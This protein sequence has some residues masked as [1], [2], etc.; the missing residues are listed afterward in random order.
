MVDMMWNLNIFQ[1]SNLAT[2][3]PR[4]WILIAKKKWEKNCQ[5]VQHDLDRRHLG[6]YID[7]V[8]LDKEVRMLGMLHLAL[9][10]KSI[11]HSEYKCV[12]KWNV[13]NSIG[14]CLNWYTAFEQEAIMLL[15]YSIYKLMGSWM[16]WSGYYV[17]SYDY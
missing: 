14:H 4:F 2:P 10:N 1:K 6:L 13:F 11:L 15:I 12:A 5:K 17:A 9:E 16:E 7:S 3:E 8:F